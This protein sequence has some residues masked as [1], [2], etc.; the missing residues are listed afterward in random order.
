MN[1]VLSHSSVKESKT[2][3]FSSWTPW[4]LTQQQRR[5]SDPTRPQSHQCKKSCK[6][7]ICWCN[8]HL[9]VRS[10]II[11]SF[12]CLDD[13]SAAQHTCV[14]APALRLKD[15]RMSWSAPH[16]SHLH[17][18]CHHLVS[19]LESVPCYCPNFQPYS[20]YHLLGLLHHHILLQTQ[21]MIISIH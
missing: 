21:Y 20:I 11:I 16:P 10:D 4:P 7:K 13:N 6:V 2:K 3:S 17:P 1:T 15:L 19:K 5:A 8:K 14:C 18:W 9:W 12:T